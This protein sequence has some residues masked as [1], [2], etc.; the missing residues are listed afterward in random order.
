[1]VIGLDA[2]VAGVYDVMHPPDGSVQEVGL[3]IPWAFL[4]F[5]DTMPVGVFEE[6]VLSVTVTVNVM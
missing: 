2:F 5:H 1:M 3:K 4:S 6:L